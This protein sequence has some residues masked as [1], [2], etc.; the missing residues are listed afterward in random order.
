MRDSNWNDLFVS[1]ASQNKYIEID[2]F[3]FV[4]WHTARGY[5]LLNTNSMKIDRRNAR[6]IIRDVVAVIAIV[7]C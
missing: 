4:Q 3:L 1:V 5:S 6:I 7:A 2:L